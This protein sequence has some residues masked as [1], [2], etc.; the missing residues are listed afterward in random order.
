MTVAF[1]KNYTD[2]SNNE[3]YQFEFHCDK[4]GNGFRSAYA[5]NKL[6]MATGLLGA[7]AGMFGGLL[8]EAAQA[9]GA[10]KDALRGKAWDDAFAA[11]IA[12]IKPKFHQCTRCGRWVCPEVCWNGK[13]SL[14]KDCAPDFAEEASAAQADALKQ[15][16]AAQLREKAEAAD[17]TAGI[18]VKRQSAA[19]CPSCSAPSTGSKFCGTCGKPMAAAP[20]ACPKCRSEIPAAAKFCPDCGTPKA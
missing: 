20:S 9:G 4:C 14:C 3:G 5:A 11:A 16:V 12:E 2:H 10:L 18:D 6:G 7:A 1:T 17:L 15:A 13:A 19:V 8:G